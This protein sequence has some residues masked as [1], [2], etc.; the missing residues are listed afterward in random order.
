MSK[1]IILG[2]SGYVG[3]HIIARLARDK[4]N[5]IIVFSRDKNP[6]IDTRQCQ[7][8]KFKNYPK[9]DAE[10][11]YHIHDAD[12]IINLI[13]TMDGNRKRAT[14]A[15]VDLVKHY[16]E[17]AKQ[18]TIK[19][20][21]QMSALGVSEKG[22]SVYFETKY[23]GEQILQETLKGSDIKISIIRPSFIFGKTAPSIDG[24]VRLINKC[25]LFMLPGAFTQFQPIYIED[26]TEA[27]ATILATQTDSMKT[28]ELT[29]PE[30]MTF[31]EMIR[32]VMRYSNLCKNKVIAMP[33]FIAHLVALTTGWIIKAP[34]TM[35][36]YNCLKVDSV[37]DNNSLPQL[38]IEPQSFQSVMSF[39]YK[40]GLQDRYEND[41][42]TA[43]RN[44]V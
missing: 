1:I 43:G 22:G 44:I 9:T 28:Y 17:L 36:Q 30:T 20:F 24:L 32:D 13:G 15:H 33:N 29:G 42:M 39:E 21:V 34:F 40:H 3:S 5:S 31:I 6:Q 38:N 18:T 4:N 25:P 16:A 12:V 8:V 27:I 2:G 35:N 11:L 23:Q 26:V 41:R 37:S 10:I 7:F 14:K 19:H